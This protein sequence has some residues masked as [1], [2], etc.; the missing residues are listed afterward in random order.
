[1]PSGARQ[2]YSFHIAGDIPDLQGLFASIFRQWIA[3]LGRRSAVGRMAH[4]FCEQWVRSRT[5]GL[6]NGDTCELALTQSDMADALGLSAVHV[7]RSL[8]ALRRE[9][10]IKLSKGKLTVLDWKRPRRTRRV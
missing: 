4:M 1:M 2:I 3:G 6:T 10:L 9:G 8:Q 5:V 7:N